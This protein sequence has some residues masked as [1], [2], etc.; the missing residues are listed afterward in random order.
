MV[1][2]SAPPIGTPRLVRHPPSPTLLDR[3]SRTEDRG[4]DTQVCRP[5]SPT[6]LH[7]PTHPP[8][9]P[10]PPPPQQP[11]APR[12]RRLSPAPAP[13]SSGSV[14]NARSGSAPSGATAM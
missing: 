2:L 11:K 14:A 5:R 12:G 4:S 9:P 6:T 1:F 8:P 7:I 10:P 13:S 3:W